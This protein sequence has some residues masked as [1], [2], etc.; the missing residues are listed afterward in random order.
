MN[1][2]NRN[3]IRPRRVTVTRLEIGTRWLYVSYV[4][5]SVTLKTLLKQGQFPW[6]IS[7]PN[8]SYSLCTLEYCHFNT[9][10]WRKNIHVNIVGFTR[11]LMSPF[12]CC[13]I[14]LHFPIRPVLRPIF[15]YWLHI[16]TIVQC[17]RNWRVILRHMYYLVYF[18]SSWNVSIKRKNTPLSIFSPLGIRTVFA[19]RQLSPEVF[20]FQA[21][22]S[23]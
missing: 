20:Q 2:V 7:S 8:Y 4:P 5:V 13:N 1:Y 6:N 12:R 14:S 23:T 21:F 10:W 22:E 17:I 9:P 11:Q 3:E 15:V 19:I 16:S 18:C